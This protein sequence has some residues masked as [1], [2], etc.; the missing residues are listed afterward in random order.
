VRNG[1]RNRPTLV[2]P[3]DGGF[4]LVVGG[5]ARGCGGR[6][7]GPSW[8]RVPFF[9]VVDAWLTSYRQRASTM[10]R[11]LRDGHWFSRSC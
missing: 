4:Y 7:D 3:E 6:A 2:F 9:L 8:G 1:P 10:L 11:L 5:Y